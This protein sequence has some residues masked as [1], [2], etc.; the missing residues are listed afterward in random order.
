MKNLLVALIVLCSSASLFAQTDDN[1]NPI[2]NSV[3]LG[4]DTVDGLTVMYNYYTLKNNIENKN[5][6]VYI[7][8]KPSLAE[9]ID[10]AQTL[11]SDFFVIM[12]GQEVVSLLLFTASPKI[13]FMLMDIKTGASK[14][15]SPA[16]QG[17]L[18][19]NRANELLTEKYAANTKI[20]GDKLTFNNAQFKIITTADIKK[21]AA[22]IIKN[23]KLK[24]ATSTGI[25]VLSQMQIKENIIKESAKGGKLDF[26]TPIIGIENN[27]VQI[28]PGIF[29]TNMGVALYKWG[30]AAFDAGVNTVDDAL[31]IY[32]ETK[33]RPV[34][35]KETLY[36]KMGFEKT[37]E[38]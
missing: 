17:T 31:A 9:T 22:A 36:I 28:K 16:L 1:N 7:D 35:K 20:K 10:A 38:K 13:E 24:D 25:Q 12:R 27:G 5:S 18:T 8:D 23:E 32:A 6:S 37:L 26:F 30:R 2:F 29:E 4:T 15:F 14:N 33:G 19:Q 21:E 11:P 34:S 3:I